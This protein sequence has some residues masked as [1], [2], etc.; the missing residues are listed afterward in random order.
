MPAGETGCPSGGR[1]LEAVPRPERPGLRP[2]RRAPATAGAAAEPPGWPPRLRLGLQ[3]LQR[4]MP[5]C[6]EVR[7][8]RRHRRPSRAPQQ[9]RQH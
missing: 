5:A 9:Q 7:L 8:R 6:A 4:F 1:C 3:G 2:G